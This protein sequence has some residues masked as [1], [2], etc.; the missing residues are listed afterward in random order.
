MS[1]V[2]RFSGWCVAMMKNPP[3]TV[4]VLASD[5]DALQQ[6]VAALEAIAEGGKRLL[7]GLKCYPRSSWNKWPL[8][9]KHLEDCTRAVPP[10][11]D[12]GDGP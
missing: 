6:R 2:E 5:Y 11:A 7:E 10:V 1:E 9:E 4:Y 3:T 12:G 8:I